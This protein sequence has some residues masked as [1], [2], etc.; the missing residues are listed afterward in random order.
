MSDIKT[1]VPFVPDF[2]TSSM[3]GF[4]PGMKEAEVTALLTG[5]PVKEE[6]KPVATDTY[7]ESMRGFASFSGPVQKL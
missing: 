5:K 3:R 4:T 1:N 6:T 7:S 2:D